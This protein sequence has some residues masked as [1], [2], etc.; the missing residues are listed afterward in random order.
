MDCLGLAWLGLSWTT[1]ITRLI[2]DWTGTKF[3]LTKILIKLL[4][5]KNKI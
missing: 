2:Y 4:L 1:L 3:T 5:I